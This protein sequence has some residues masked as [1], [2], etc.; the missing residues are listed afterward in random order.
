MVSASEPT[1]TSRLVLPMAFLMVWRYRRP[2]L[3]SAVQPGGTLYGLQHSNPVDPEIAYHG[4]SYLYGTIYDPLIGQRVGG[5][6]VFGG[7]LAL[8]ANGGK[9]VGGV[10]VSGDTS[11]TDHFVAWRVRNLLGLDH[12][13]PIAAGVGGVSNDQNRPDNIVFDFFNTPDG[14]ILN[15]NSSGDANNGKL[16]GS[17][18]GWGHPKCDAGKGTLDPATL[19]AVQHN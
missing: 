18:S 6:N 9:K 19:P 16:V 8:F 1:P 17:G 11:C 12:F 7:G 14:G 4:A 5:V 15:P 2:I 10:G 13:G 3:Y